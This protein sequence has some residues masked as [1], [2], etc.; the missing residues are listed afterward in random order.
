VKLP[1]RVAL[2]TR[3]ARRP[4]RAVALRLA[5]EGAVR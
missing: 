4:R 1:D 5:Q 3:A 2:V